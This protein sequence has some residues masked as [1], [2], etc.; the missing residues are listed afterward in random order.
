MTQQ[1]D[2]RF[3]YLASPYS[4]YPGGPEEAFREVCKAA[5]W[6][7]RIGLP[8]FCPIAM[9]HPIAVHGGMDPMDCEAWL[10]VDRPF[11]DAACG[12]IVCRME[13]WQESVGVRHE[14]D[15]FLAAGKPVLYYDP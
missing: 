15:V 7:T 2:G 10:K 4:R 3:W 13:G 11:M 6:F 14:I 5:A 12:L 1:T 9:T 8:V